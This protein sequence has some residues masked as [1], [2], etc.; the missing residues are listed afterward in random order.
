MKRPYL[1][2]LE[3]LGE[4]SLTV[5]GPLAVADKRVFM[6]IELVVGSLQICCLHSLKIPSIPV[7]A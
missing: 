1:V 3:L 7:A 5:V 2:L 4:V 6:A